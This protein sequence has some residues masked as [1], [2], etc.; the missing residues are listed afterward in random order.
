MPTVLDLIA[1]PALRE[2]MIRSLRQQGERGSLGSSCEDRLL[3]SG[4]AWESYLALDEALGHDRSSPRLYFLDEVVE[5]M[6]TAEKHEELKKWL[7]TLLEQYFIARSIRAFPRGQATLKRLREAGAEPDES[8]SFQ[9]RKEVPDLVLEVALT[10]GGLPKLEIYQRFS[11]PEVWFWRK[12]NLEIWVF[13]EGIY[14]GPLLAS[15]LLP[16]L[17]LDLLIRCATIPD[18][19]TAIDSFRKGLSAAS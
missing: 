16:D 17:P 13:E 3:L 8:W 18:W 15:R 10:S 2:P 19:I 7:A 6:S 9:D 1:E 5:I 4:V 11:I 14:T 12:D